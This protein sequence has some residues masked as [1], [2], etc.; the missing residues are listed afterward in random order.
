MSHIKEEHEPP[1]IVGKKAKLV[2]GAL[3][4]AIALGKVMAGSTGG[5]G[6]PPNPSGQSTVEDNEPTP[7][8]N[9]TTSGEEVAPAAGYRLPREEWLFK[10]NMFHW[11]TIRLPFRKTAQIPECDVFKNIYQ[12]GE[13]DNIFLLDN[14][15]MYPFACWLTMTNN[16]N[17]TDNADLAFGCYKN[18]VFV[19]CI[20]ESVN[21]AQ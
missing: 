9:R 15:T 19:E 7:H 8:D 5:G 2:G 20:I 1:V 10:G 4:S 14:L 3:A 21:F 12:Y 6:K 11:T 16:W 13:N 18:G 17:T